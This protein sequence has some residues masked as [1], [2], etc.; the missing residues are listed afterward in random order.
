MHKSTSIGEKVYAIGAPLGLELSISDGLVSGE[1]RHGT[2][3][4]LQTTAAISPGSSGGGLFNAQGQLVGI[5]TA[6]IADGQ[7]L[8]FAIPVDD[9]Y[10]VDHQ[11]AQETGENWMLLADQIL[12]KAK[13]VTW[14]TEGVPDLMNMTLRQQ[15]EWAARQDARVQ[16]MRRQ[17][18]YAIPAYVEAT[19]LIP[20]DVRPWLHLASAY[21]K[22]KEPQLMESAYRQALALAPRDT[23]VWAEVA[24]S[25]TALGQRIDA[26]AAYDEA[27]RLAPNNLAL[28][29]G[30][31]Q[32]Y[33]GFDRKQAEMTLASAARVAK[34]SGDFCLL[35]MSYDSVN[36]HLKAEKAYLNA[37]MLKPHDPYTLSFLGLHYARIGKK[38]KAKQIYQELKPLDAIA[39][40][41][42][43]SVIEMR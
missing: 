11:T 15:E 14:R 13:A 32:T 36:Q 22:L 4:W 16:E 5:T 28:H 31:F 8:N 10:R 21:K 24:E 42:L 12:D 37:L 1:R 19:R 23:S 20:N 35:A 7:N 2:H 6:S 18:T 3:T 25:R 43:L 34:D 40:G 39:A 30:L 38:S 17:I 27:I 41:R 9:V 33:L 29:I 26:V